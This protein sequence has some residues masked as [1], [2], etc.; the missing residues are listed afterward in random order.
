MSRAFD[1]SGW[2]DGVTV[3]HV[4]DYQHIATDLYTRGAPVDGGGYGR[5][6][7]GFIGLVPGALPGTTCTVTGAA[8]AGGVATLTIGGHVVGVNQ[9]VTVTGVTPTG[10]NVV[11]A[12]VTAVTGTTIS[13]ALSA[14]PGAWSSGG[15]VLVGSVPGFGTIAAD[16]NLNMKCWNGTS[17]TAVATAISA[18]TWWSG[19]GVPSSGL[20][21]NGDMYLNLTGAGKGD[22]YGPKTAGSWGSAGM[23]VMGPQGNQGIQGVQGTQGIQGIQGI[24]GP[25][26]VSYT[27]Q[28][29][30]FVGVNYVQ[31]DETTYNSKLYISLQSL[32]INHQPDISPTWWQPVVTAFGAADQ[33]FT[34][35]A[36]QTT[37]TPTVAPL[38]TCFVFVNGLKQ[39][40]GAT[41]DYTVVGTSVVFNAGLIAGDVVEIVQ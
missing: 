14:N 2:T 18:G 3:V 40:N 23:N 10:Y 35:T 34:A 7:T 9:L 26:G 31:G 28:G 37:F 21:S 12:A 1:P 25:P 13:F 38:A 29:V 17:W 16:S 24:Q 30:Y 4:A 39:R 6:N 41:Y 8:W 5:A 22:V 11:Q 15:S 33:F 19:S 36:A 20:G 27:P 32:N